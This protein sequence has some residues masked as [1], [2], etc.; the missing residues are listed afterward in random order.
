MRRLAKSPVQSIAV[1]GSDCGAILVIRDK[2]QQQLPRALAEGEELGSNLL[3][4]ILRG[5]K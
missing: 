1:N 5:G 3:H 4:A 2:G